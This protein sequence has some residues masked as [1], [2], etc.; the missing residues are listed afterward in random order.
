[1]EHDKNPNPEPAIDTESSVKTA[2]DP[3]EPAKTQF[4]DYKITPKYAPKEEAVPAT[5][6]IDAVLTK[7]AN[8]ETNLATLETARKQIEAKMKE[9][10]AKVDQ[11]GNR[12]E[13]EAQLQE[14]IEKAA[15]LISAVNSKVVQWKD[16]LYTLQTE[17]VSYVPKLTPKEMLSKIYAKFDGAEK[18]VQDVLNGM[19]SQAKNVMENTLIRWPNKKSSLNK[20]ATILDDMNHYNDEL[21]AAL[22]E[23]S[24]PL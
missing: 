20:E 19:L 5:P 16:K 1:M 24:S 17:E 7:M 6:E 22:K 8:L 3:V 23:L 15:V 13:M 10:L 12:V 18:Y 4:K 9:E 2:A 11:S 21:M 14:S